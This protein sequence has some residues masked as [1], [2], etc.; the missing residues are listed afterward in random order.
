MATSMMRSAR[1]TG[2]RDGVP[3]R[4]ASR[5]EPRRPRT[6]LG[7]SSKRWQRLRHTHESTTSASKPCIGYGALSRGELRRTWPMHTK[8]QRQAHEARDTG[9]T[10]VRPLSSPPTVKWGQAMTTSGGGTRPF[11]VNLTANSRALWSRNIAKKP[12]RKGTF[13]QECPSIV[14]CFP[15]GPPRSEPLHPCLPQSRVRRS[16]LATPTTATPVIHANTRSSRRPTQRRTRTWCSHVRTAAIRSRHDQCVIA[17][18]VLAPM[19]TPGLARSRRT[20]PAVALPSSA[21]STLWS[22][23]HH[24]RCGEPRLEI[25]VPVRSRGGAAAG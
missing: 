21:M 7:A 19:S 6:S 23:K 17:A 3:S 4:S 13:S 8:R 22:P 2:C 18:L 16:A 1:V 24:A 10:W 5:P 15:T 11:N 9:D 14:S 12:S 25:A 20:A